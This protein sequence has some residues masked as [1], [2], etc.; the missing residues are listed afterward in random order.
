[1]NHFPW[2]KF[3]SQF[4][5]GQ[6][7]LTL[8]SSFVNYGHCV[9][10]KLT[11]QLPGS[12]Y[13]LDVIWPVWVAAPWWVLVDAV[14]TNWPLFINWVQFGFG[15]VAGL[16]HS[17]GNGQCI[18]HTGHFVCYWALCVLLTSHQALWQQQQ[19]QSNVRTTNI[20][21][22]NRGSVF[23]IRAQPKLV[24]LNST[25]WEERESNPFWYIGKIATGSGGGRFRLRRQ[26]CWENP[27]HRSLCCLLPSFFSSFDNW[28]QYFLPFPTQKFTVHSMILRL[29][30][31][32]SDFFASP[33]NWPQYPSFHLPLLTNFQPASFRIPCCMFISANMSM[34]GILHRADLLLIWPNCFLA[35]IDHPQSLHH[36]VPQEILWASWIGYP[37]VHLIFDM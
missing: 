13:K 7:S 21:E 2:A 35:Q 3:E 32:S 15:W 31:L 34:F 19:R 11:H 18:T 17:G 30:L 14:R 20:E 23:L 36:F 29:L 4:Q 27:T 16:V 28:P 33:D 24:P 25:V 10:T 9:M 37:E 6:F 8:P 1:M 22:D 26:F 5:F 12:V